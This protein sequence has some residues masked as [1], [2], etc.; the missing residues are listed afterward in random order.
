MLA[1]VFQFLIYIP[2][3]WLVGLQTRKVEIEKGACLLIRLDA[4]GDYV[5]FRNFVRAFKDSE[6]YRDVRVTLVGNQA[7]KDLAL[8]LDEKYFDGYIWIDRN[9]FVWNIFYRYRKLKE[10]RSNGWEYVISPRHSREAFFEDAIVRIVKGVHKIGTIGDLAIIRKWQQWFGNRYYTQLMV[11]RPGIMFEFGRNKEFF[12]WLL[13]GQ[14]HINK[15]EITVGDY[16]AALPIKLPTHYVVVYIGGS[17]PFRKWSVA[18]HAKVARYVADKYH[19]QIVLCGPMPSDDEDVK[20]ADVFKGNYWDCLGKTTFNDL[21]GIIGG[22]DLIISNE[23]FIPHLAVGL[24]KKVVVISNGNHYGR[25]TP[26]PSEITNK[27]WGV[28]H[29]LIENM[30]H[31]YKC[32]S[33]TYGQGSRLNINAVVPSRVMAIVDVAMSA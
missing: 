27:Y 32:L 16:V 22:A 14:T 11:P 1:E 18:N 15:P 13:R 8:V 21:I 24:G 6:K 5:L 9:K 29:P 31:D 7:W 23:T 19:S 17:A 25:F 12:E 4:I 26:Y 3:E 30:A 28:Y 2:I 10:L 20:F 33:D